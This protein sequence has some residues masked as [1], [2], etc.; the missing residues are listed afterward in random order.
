MVPDGSGLE[1]HAGLMLP[2]KL[3]VIVEIRCSLSHDNIGALAQSQVPLI[4]LRKLSNLDNNTHMKQ[5]LPHSP[6]ANPTSLVMSV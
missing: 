4:A 6:P 5:N 3:I 2:K 1:N